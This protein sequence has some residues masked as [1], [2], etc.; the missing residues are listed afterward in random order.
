MNIESSDMLNGIVGG[1]AINQTIQTITADQVI[2]NTKSK[3]SRLL[4]FTILI[5][6]GVTLYLFFKKQNEKN[7][8][9][10]LENKLSPKKDID[11]TK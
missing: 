11:Q 8:I 1:E 5:I 6:L 7:V 3:S 4:F 2:A 10:N 9:K